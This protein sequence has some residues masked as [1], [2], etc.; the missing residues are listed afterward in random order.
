LEMELTELGLEDRAEFMTCMGLE[1]LALEQ[2]IET[3]YELLDLVTFYTTVGAELRAWTVA[4]GATAPR[5]AGRIHSDMEEG[6]IKAEVIPFPAFEAAGSEQRAR[7]AG[8]MRV[9]GRDYVIQD[10]DVVYF[11]FKA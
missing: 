8:D 11:H 6:F 2:V 1:K 10:G 9:E 3:G 7:R 5:A 4:G